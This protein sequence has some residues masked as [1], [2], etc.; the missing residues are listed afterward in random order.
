MKNNRKY[1]LFVGVLF[2]LIIIIFLEII[3]QDK[4]VNL[5]Y[6][7]G[8]IG[9]ISILLNKNNLKNE[10]PIEMLEFDLKKDDIIN[11]LSEILLCKKY[12]NGLY[13]DTE[14]EIKYFIKKTD[15]IAIVFSNEVTDVMYNQY[16]ENA[17]K[18][19]G[20]YIKKKY[21]IKKTSKISVTYIIN[22]NSYNENLLKCIIEPKKNHWCH[23]YLLVAIVNDAKKM[24]IEMPKKFVRNTKYSLLLKK[25]YKYLQCDIKQIKNW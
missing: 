23:Y 25:I 13:K 22:V 16:S 17:F 3:D 14:C 7:M 6:G 18:E 5:F 10:L 8:L 1:I 2:Y 9:C 11:K 12:T 20:D 24:Y 15:I 21:E 19:F 4:L